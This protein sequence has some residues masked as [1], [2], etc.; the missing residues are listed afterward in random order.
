MDSIGYDE[1]SAKNDEILGRKKPVFFKEPCFCFK[2]PAFFTDPA[3]LQ[4]LGS[5]G[6]FNYIYIHIYI[7]IYNHVYNIYIYIYLG[8]QR[9]KK[10]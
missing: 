8:L 4:V 7:Y 3:I 10:K 1:A 6:T 9:P 5:L 2:N